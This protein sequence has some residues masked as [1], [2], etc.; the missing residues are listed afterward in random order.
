MK[1]GRVIA[2]RFEPGAG[3]V[4]LSCLLVAGPVVTQ[5]GNGRNGATDDSATARYDALFANPG[6]TPVPQDNI[7]ATAPGV[8]Q[9]AR[10]SQFTFNILAPFNYSSNAEVAD[11][12][13]TQTAEFS[14]RIN[15]AWSTPVFDLPLRFSANLFA[16]SG[17]YTQPAAYGANFDKLGGSARLQYIDPGNDQAYSPYISQAARALRLTLSSKAGK[18]SWN[19]T[20]PE[21]GGFII[22]TSLGTKMTMAVADW[23]AIEVASEAIYLCERPTHEGLL[24]LGPL[25]VR[26]VIQ[27]FRSRFAS[28]QVRSVWA[29]FARLHCK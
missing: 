6:R 24:G 4:L 8:E 3:A 28:T 16:E 7:F 18:A 19:S 25:A 17:R 29:A 23:D 27:E 12:G 13:G 2:R 22:S 15:A 10:R 5:S 26:K 20:D 11:T 9:Q 1:K 21:N 14:P